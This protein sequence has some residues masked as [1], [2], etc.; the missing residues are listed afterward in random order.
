MNCNDTLPP[1]PG[2]DNDVFEIC[3]VARAFEIAGSKWRLTVLRCLHLWGE[4]RF[5]E[6]QETSTADSA[7]LSRVLGELEERNLV[8][9]RLEDRPIAT[10]YS[11]TE[12]GEALA[13]VFDAFEEWALEWTVADLPEGQSPK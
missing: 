5:S 3:P 7:T 6:L 11:L 12:R 8:S 2:R 13:G 9:R 1:K 4:Q 10:Y